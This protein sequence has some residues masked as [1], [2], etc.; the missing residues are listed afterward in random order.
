MLTE[1]KYVSN[2]GSLKGTGRQNPVGDTF[3]DSFASHYT[4]ISRE[5]PLY[6]EL[7]NLFHHVALT[8][9]IRYQDVFQT[10]GLYPKYLIDEFPL[11][12][13]EVGRTLPGLSFL[14]Q[15][16]IND[17][18]KHKVKNNIFWIPTCGGV[19]IDIKVDKTTVSQDTTG[20]L[21]EQVKAIKDAR[22]SPDSLSWDIPIGKE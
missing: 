17:H 14:K 18:S 11:K 2:A 1:E 19:C 22:P 16:D 20:K 9:L 7:Q 4:E 15:V 12:V 6:R 13:T 21:D 5:K 10:A 3:A 8:Q